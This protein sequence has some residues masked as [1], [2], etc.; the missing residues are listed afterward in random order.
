MRVLLTGGAGFIGS[1]TAVALAEAGHQPLIVDDLSNARRDAI[2]RIRE[3]AGTPV[4]ALIADVRDESA[5]SGFLTANG[6]VDAVIHLAGLKAVGESVAEP[7]RYYE[8]NLSTTLALLRTMSAQGI[9]R[10]VFSSSATVYGSAGAMPLTEDSETGSGITNPYGRTKHMIEKILADVCTATPSFR[11]AALRYFNPVG[12]HPSGLLGEDPLGVPNNLMPVVA[13]VAGGMVE[14]VSVFGTDYPTA[15]GTAE[16]DYIHV[17]DLARGHV[18]AIERLAPGFDAVNLGTGEPSSV[19]E[20]IRAYRE[21]SGAEIPYRH[22]GRRP[23][24]LPVAFAD[25]EKAARVLG[26]RAELT[27]ADAC[28]DDWNWRRSQAA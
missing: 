1:H 28:R 21:A 25:V 12:A 18:H 6:P 24:D 19:L 23:G 17:Q 27:L 16:R 15:D 9:D 2:D 10:M 8:V 7:V 22:A 11:C 20:V 5:L 3:L 26:W 14:A 4:P 13:K